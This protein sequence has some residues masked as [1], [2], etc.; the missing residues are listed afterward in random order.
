MFVCYDDGTGNKNTKK[1]GR[2]N[3]RQEDFS[4]ENKEV[5][6][7]EAGAIGYCDHCGFAIYRACD[8]LRIRATDDRIH[9]DCWS[10]YAEEHMF[11]LAETA[12]DSDDFDCAC[13]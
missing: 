4:C 6:P 5:F 8:A 9:K 12:E 11:E 13:E 10:D 7:S 3:M 1:G 2:S